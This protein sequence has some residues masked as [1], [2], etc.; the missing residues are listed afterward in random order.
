VLQSM[1]ALIVAQQPADEAAVLHAH[2]DDLLDYF[3]ETAQQPVGYH[4]TCMCLRTETNMHGFDTWMLVPLGVVPPA[5]R[6][7]H[8][9]NSEVSVGRP[10]DARAGVPRWH[11]AEHCARSVDSALLPD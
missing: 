9:H 6:G 10:T 5:L 4:P 3:D 8:L 2:C 7:M 11:R 1:V